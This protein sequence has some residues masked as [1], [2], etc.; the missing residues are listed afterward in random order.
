M[1]FA[2]LP[3]VTLVIHVGLEPE[4][5][6]VITSSLGGLVALH[7]LYHLLFMCKVTTHEAV[8]VGTTT[9]K[10]LQGRSRS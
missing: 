3:V 6:G 9:F 4:G 10:T 8:H 2:N 5:R 7:I 1:S